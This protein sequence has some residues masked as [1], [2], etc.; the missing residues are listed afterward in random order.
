M[1]LRVD[2][3]GRLA[4]SWK[5]KSA[6]PNEAPCTSS[7]ESTNVESPSITVIE[8]RLRAGGALSHESWAVTVAWIDT[9]CW[10]GGHSAEGESETWRLG[11]SISRTV[12][13][14]SSCDGT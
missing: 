13:R 12:T 8:N 7:A 1:Y 10:L 6:V 14:T 5:S 3:G 9:S 4:R 11:P 2:P